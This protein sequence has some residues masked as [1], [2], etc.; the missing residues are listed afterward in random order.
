MMIEIPLPEPK[1]FPL[2]LYAI[3]LLVGVGLGVFVLEPFFKNPRKFFND[4]NETVD[5]IM[6]SEHPEV[7]KSEIKKEMKTKYTKNDLAFDYGYSIGEKVRNW[8]KSLDHLFHKS[9]PLDNAHISA[10][11]K[12][13]KRVAQNRNKFRRR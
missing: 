12:Q 6:G 4:I 13:P 7:K 2:W 11:D 5:Y 1:E 8:L 3:G 10:M 9:R